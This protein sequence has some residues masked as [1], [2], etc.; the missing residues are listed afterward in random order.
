MNFSR[1]FKV[2]KTGGICIHF[3]GAKGA[4]TPFLDFPLGRKEIKKQRQK[5]LPPP[6]Y[7]YQTFLFYISVA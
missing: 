7:P 2:R 3:A 4:N 1:D 6:L 5:L